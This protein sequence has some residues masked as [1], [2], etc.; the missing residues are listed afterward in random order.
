MIRDVLLAL[1]F[2]T[3]ITMRFRS[4]VTEHYCGNATADIEV[5]S[6]DTRRDLTGKGTHIDR[7]IIPLQSI[8]PKKVRRIQRIER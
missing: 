7:G 5:L 4:T 3:I 1:P 8:I 6:S 2:R